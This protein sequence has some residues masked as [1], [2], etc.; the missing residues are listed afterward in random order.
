MAHI[1]LRR[2]AAIIPLVVAVASGGYASAAEDS[3]SATEDHL[4]ESA[5]PLAR[6][7]PYIES[8]KATLESGRSTDEIAE[9]LLGSGRPTA[10]NLQALCR[11]YKKA[12]PKFD[13]MQS[14][15][16][17][18]EDG[19]GEYSKWYEIYRTAQSE[20]RDAATLD[21]LAQQKADALASFTKLL[22]NRQWLTEGGAPTRLQTIEA[23]LKER[24]G[25]PRFGSPRK[26]GPERARL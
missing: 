26:R 4:G 2:L 21:R 15:F 20:G 16:K 10:F 8:L 13:E 11:L 25:Q 14:D 1:T 19:I 5:A 6:F 12:D 9:S 24:I 23:F 3:L 17:G 18:L 22:T 7:A